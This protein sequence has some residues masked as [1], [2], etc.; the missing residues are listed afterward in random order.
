MLMTGGIGEWG[1]PGDGVGPVWL[2]AQRVIIDELGRLTDHTHIS[3]EELQ[4]AQGQ[5]G[6]EDWLR[7]EYDPKAA[8]ES[9]LA[10]RR[11]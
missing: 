11:R 7:H 5:I 1:A 10:G 6:I 8:T 3:L 4:R 9:F 2:E